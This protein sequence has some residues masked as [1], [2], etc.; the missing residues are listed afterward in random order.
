MGWGGG[1][2]FYPSP[3]WDV[4]W[5]D[6]VDTVGV[7]RVSAHLDPILDQVEPN[8]PATWNPCS[9]KF[10]EKTMVFLVF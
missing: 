8:S 3:L 6:L 9:H 2:G 7:V 10:I 4:G 5:W 1:M